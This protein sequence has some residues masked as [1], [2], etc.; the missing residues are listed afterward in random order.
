MQKHVKMMHKRY[1]KQIVNEIN[2]LHPKHSQDFWRYINQLR[3]IDAVEEETSVSSEYWICHYQ[4]LLYDSKEPHITLDFSN[5]D[6]GLEH[7]NSPNDDI[8]GQPITTNEIHEQISKLKL[9]KASVIDC[10]NSLMR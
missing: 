7:E 6:L 10:I 8:L 3:K 5:E 2:T 4:K 9:K 1:K